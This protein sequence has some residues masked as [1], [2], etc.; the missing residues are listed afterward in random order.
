MPGFSVDAV[1]VDGLAYVAACDTVAVV[2]LESES[3]V[4]QTWVANAYDGERLVAPA[5]GVEVM[6]D[7]AFIAAGRYGAVA[8]DVSAPESPEVLGHCTVAD[9]LSF[10]GSGVQADG[11]TLHVAGGEWGILSVDATD[12]QVACS[13]TA[14]C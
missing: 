13:A 6:G 5:R 11:D 3:V 9:D 2:D 10:Y 1:V 7:V 4:G 8:V 14:N 12:A